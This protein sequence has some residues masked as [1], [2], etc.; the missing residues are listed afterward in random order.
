MITRILRKPTFK[1]R[2]LRPFSKF[3]NDAS[4]TE[5]PISDRVVS[6]PEWPVPYYQRLYR[7]YPVRDNTQQDL[8][9]VG[10]KFGDLMVWHAKEDFSRTQEGR[11]IVTHVED[12]LE[13]DGKIFS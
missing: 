5:R 11:E 3:I 7:S 1:T 9:S 13:L 6:T 12:N 8:S 2:I 4:A 10:A